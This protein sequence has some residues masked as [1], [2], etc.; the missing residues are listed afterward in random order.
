MFLGDWTTIQ[1]AACKKAL[2]AE[3][4]T[5]TARIREGFQKASE[6]VDPAQALLNIG[7]KEFTNAGKDKS[8]IN[9]SPSRYWFNKAQ[10]IHSAITNKEMVKA[11][12]DDEE[13]KTVYVDPFS[14]YF[15]GN[16]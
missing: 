2:A 13:G 16:T 1:K 14:Y 15:G 10:E 7:S 3:Y 8:D 6:I 11:G 5:V 9:N 12:W 4:Y